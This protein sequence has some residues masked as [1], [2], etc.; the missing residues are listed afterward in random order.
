MHQASLHSV[1]LMESLLRR[2]S[3]DQCWILSSTQVALE[4][5]REEE[6]PQF[7]T[8]NK[9]N[10]NA[11]SDP[12]DFVVILR[13]GTTLFLLS[14]CFIKYFKCH[15][16]A[17]WGQGSR[18]WR[19]PCELWLPQYFRTIVTKSRSL[20]NKLEAPETLPHRWF[21]WWEEKAYTDIVSCEHKGL[22]VDLCKTM[23]LDSAG[24]RSCRRHTSSLQKKR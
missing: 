7:N 19:A 18:G 2:P 24:H 3:S 16:Q 21:Q 12:G 6:E 4:R 20:L 1:L 11:V 23:R 8:L 13:Y 9:G 15:L 10:K 5:L 14:P 17:D 22:D